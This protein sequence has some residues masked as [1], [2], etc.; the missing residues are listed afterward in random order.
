MNSETKLFLGILLTTVVIIGG[1]IFAFSRP[2]NAPLVDSKLLMPGDSY[3]IG[4]PSA[5]VLL[6]EFGDFQCPACGAY[7]LVVKQLLEKYKDS[8]A[9]VFRHFPL[10]M[11]PNAVPASIAV[12][13]AG[14]QGKFWE[15]YNKVYESQKEWSAEKDTGNI[16]AEYALSLS[17]NVEQFRTDVKDPALKKKID[18]DVAD[19][20]ALGINSTPSF[21]LNGE[22]IQNPASLE[23]F[24]TLIKAAILKAPKPSIAAEEKYHIHANLS[25]ILDGT[26]VNFKLA[27]YQSTESKELNEFIHFHDGKGDMFHVHKKG[28]LLKDLFTS[29]GMTLSKDCLVTDTKQ[30]YCSKGEKTLKVYVNNKVNTLYEL[31]EPQ[32]LDRILISYGTETS[33][34]FISQLQSVADDACIYSEK[35]PERGKPPTEECV[36][37]LGSDCEQK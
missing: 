27:K 11:H 5:T 34:A 23:D 29:L 4:S 7:H 26:P 9:L 2:S 18:R 21:F 30:S 1:A 28:M 36:G 14:K 37:G 20:T 6:V 35:C 15:M 24:E 17:L 32:D 13:A 31:Y 10:P 22:R 33:Q 8:V 3:K 16:F 12:E 19:A 25:V